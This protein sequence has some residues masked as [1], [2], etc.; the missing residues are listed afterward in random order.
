MFAICHDAT[1]GSRP[2]F[3]DR[4]GGFFWEGR[5]GTSPGPLWGGRVV[6]AG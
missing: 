6:G 5:G 1:D 3:H 4:T 2:S